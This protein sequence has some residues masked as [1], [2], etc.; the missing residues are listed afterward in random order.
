MESEVFIGAIVLR[1]S[2]TGDE[3]LIDLWVHGKSKTTARYYRSEA[4]RFLGFVGMSLSMVS[5]SDL[6]GFADELDNLG[7]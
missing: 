2:V 3:Q 6:Q 4:L 1:E 5:L 7:V